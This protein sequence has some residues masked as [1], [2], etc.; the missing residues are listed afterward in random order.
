MNEFTSFLYSQRFQQNTGDPHSTSTV[1]RGASTVQMFHLG[2][3]HS[4]ATNKAVRSATMAL[5]SDAC[6]RLCGL[7]VRHELNGETVTLVDKDKNSDR[8]FVRTTE[9]TVLA[10]KAVNVEFWSDGARR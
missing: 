3:L 1:G 4:E 5:N 9:G 6:M 8:W 7:T 10:V 2:S